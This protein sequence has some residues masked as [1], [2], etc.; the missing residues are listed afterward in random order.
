MV[1]TTESLIYWTN[2][3]SVGTFDQTFWCM[4]DLNNT[5]VYVIFFTSTKVKY[6]LTTES[7][8]SLDQ[9]CLALSLDYVLLKMT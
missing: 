9:F 7:Y 1:Y 3:V 5:E 2:F 4:I 8:E 6:G